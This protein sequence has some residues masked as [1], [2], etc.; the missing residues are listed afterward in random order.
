[1]RALAVFIVLA[2]VVLPFTACGTGGD[3][4]DCLGACD[5]C[6]SNSICCGDAICSINTTDGFP[7]CE[8]SGHQCKLGN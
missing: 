7:R 6:S 1:M 5:V 3:S 8:S 2:L 4:H